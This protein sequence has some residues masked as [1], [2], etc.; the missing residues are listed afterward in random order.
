MTLKEHITESRTIKLLIQAGVFITSRVFYVT[1][2]S[3]SWGL[4]LEVFWNVI[5]LWKVVLR[6]A[7]HGA[8]YASVLSKSQ[9]IK[10]RKL[11]L[12]GECL[13]CMLA[14]VCTI[15]CILMKL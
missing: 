4:L 1:C 8:N 7:I 6:F 14:L 12:D 5:T 2:S 11:L 9:L 15:V 13:I 10:D 3:R